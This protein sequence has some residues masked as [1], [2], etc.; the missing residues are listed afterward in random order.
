M[1]MKAALWGAFAL[2]IGALAS[3]ASA[4][5]GAGRVTIGGLVDLVERNS[6]DDL[7]N[8]N[9]AQTSNLD[10]VRTRLFLDAALDD[11][12]QLFT[13]LVFWG[14]GDL[15]LYGAYV[16]FEDVGGSAASL[17]VGLIPATVGQW[18]PR[19]YSDSNPLVGVPLA[20]NHHT[21]MTPKERQT[22]VA[23][24]LEARDRRPQ[25]GLPI[26]YD[27]CW[28]T[29]V[30]VYGPLG[31]FDWSLGVLTGS[32]T[33]PARDRVKS[34]PQGTTRVV[35]HASPGV[36]L[37]A[38]GWIGPYLWDELPVAEGADVGGLLNA[39]FGGDVAWTLRYL[40]LHAEA[41]HARWEHPFL[42]TLTATAGYVEAKRKL[43][44]R[45]YAAGRLEAFQPGEVR[46]ETGRRTR[47]DY[48]VRRAEYG[49]GFHPSRRITLKAVVQSDWF[50]G[51]DPALDETHYVGQLSARF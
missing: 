25:S 15:F 11:G 16:R 3:T 18:G 41:F 8:R 30:E 10:P 43:A 20:E 5:P 35:W 17:N 33:E 13:Q 19:T 45:W 31:D 44:A 29:G 26:L 34:V 51:G 27:N 9:F 2:G 21:A 36:A 7:T 46:D 49:L 48:P 38:S 24:L 4:S 23:D 22:T 40:E 39:G 6:E 50:V 32:V 28:G 14:Y 1:A 12:V 47:W 37:G 42:P